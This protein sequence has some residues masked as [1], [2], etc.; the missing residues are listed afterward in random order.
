MSRGRANSS[1]GSSDDGGDDGSE[2]FECIAGDSDVSGDDVPAPKRRKVM[3][4][5]APRPRRGA[6]AA[7]TVAYPTAPAAVACGADAITLID[8]LPDSD[9]A[10]EHLVRKLKHE[11]RDFFRRFLPQEQLNMHHFFGIIN[12]SPGSGKSTLL[13][14]L[15]WALKDMVED[16]MVMTTSDNTIERLRG[17][18][19]PLNLIKVREEQL[20]AF[21]DSDSDDSSDDG[22]QMEAPVRT[23]SWGEAEKHIANVLRKNKKRNTRRERLWRKRGSHGTFAPRFTPI[24]LDDMA[25]DVTKLKSKMFMFLYANYRHSF[26]PPIIVTQFLSQAPKEMTGAATHFFTYNIV[27]DASREK[28]FKTCFTDVPKKK[29]FYDI[30]NKTTACPTP[31]DNPEQRSC[32]VKNVTWQRAGKPW[33]ECIFYIHPNDE[34]T[35]QEWRVGHDIM[36]AA[37]QMVMITPQQRRS[38]ALADKARR[39]VEAQEVAAAAQRAEEAARV[40]KERARQASALRRVEGQLARNPALEDELPSIVDQALSSCGP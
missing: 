30:L 19:Q 26:C 39:Q 6:G 14:H 7:R 24:V 12:G 22:E 15:L 33:K 1:S 27:E 13:I 16:V 11:N 38:R 32:L 3:S 34:L 2:L 25:S 31:E 29:L 36:H 20:G 17:R 28:L 9:E 40:E 18:V 8:E 35:R 21:A 10:K 4:A 37:G 5:A 23:M